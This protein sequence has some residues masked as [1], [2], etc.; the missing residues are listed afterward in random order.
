MVPLS[1]QL[2]A[3][4]QREARER[5]GFHA[6][7]VGVLSD[8]AVIDRILKVVYEA[9]SVFPEDHLREL[10][11]GGYAIPPGHDYSPMEAYFVRYIGR[12]MDALV[13]GRLQPFHPAQARFVAA[14]RGQRPASLPVERAWLKLDKDLPGRHGSESAVKTHNP[15]AAHRRLRIVSP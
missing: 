1:S 12:Y 11:K 4:A 9:R 8:P 14:C 2:V 10:L 6:T 5:I 13:E 15:A 3:D 7:H